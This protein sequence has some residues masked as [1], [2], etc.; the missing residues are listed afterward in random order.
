VDLDI[1]SLEPR[2]GDRYLLCSDGV[3]KMVSDGRI[4]D[5]VLGAYDAEG[6][7][8]DLVDIANESGG[9]DNITALLIFFEGP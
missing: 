6:G 7:C 2:V 9:R 3:T 5:V 1:R 8:R 4:R